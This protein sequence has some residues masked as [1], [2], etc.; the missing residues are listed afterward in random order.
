MSEAR[1]APPVVAFCPYCGDPL[2]SF[3]GTRLADGERVC[4]RCG[5]CFRII[6]VDLDETE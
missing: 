6:H 5:E 4:E 2:G 3:F 1:D